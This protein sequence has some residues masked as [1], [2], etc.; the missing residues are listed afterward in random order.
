MTNVALNM[1]MPTCNQ[2]STKIK[3]WL[4]QKKVKVIKGNAKIDL[5]HSNENKLFCRSFSTSQ[6]IFQYIRKDFKKPF[7]KSSFSEIKTILFFICYLVTPQ[8]ILG[9]CGRNSFTQTVPCDKAGSQGQVERPA[10]T[11]TFPIPIPSSSMP[12]SN[13]DNISNKALKYSQEN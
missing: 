9:H 4:H 1:R 8:P 7:C 11:D 12:S 5:K 10:L 3:T 13:Y 2:F 6:Q